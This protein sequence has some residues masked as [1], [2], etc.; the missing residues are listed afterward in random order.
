MALLPIENLR[1]RAER[2]CC[3]HVFASQIHESFLIMCLDSVRDYPYQT[4][5][6]FHMG[7]RLVSNASAPLAPLRGAGVFK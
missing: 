7:L 4:C 6:R 2:H 5:S 1:K 3:A